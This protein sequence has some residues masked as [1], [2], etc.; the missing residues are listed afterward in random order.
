[1]ITIP[2]NELALWSVGR[3]ALCNEFDLPSNDATEDEV[4]SVDVGRA[5]L[6]DVDDAILSQMKFAALRIETDHAGT[7]D[8]SSSF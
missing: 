8:G 5:V 6:P 2:L 4:V 1:M 3:T 7:A